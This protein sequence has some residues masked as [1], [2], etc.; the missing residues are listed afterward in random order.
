MA[1]LTTPDN[2]HVN[3]RWAPITSL[4]SRLTRAP[5][6]V[7]VKKAT[8]M[9]CTWREHGAAQVED[10]ALA[11]PRRLPALR[12]ADGGLEQRDEAMITAMRHPARRR[13]RS[14]ISST[15][16]PASTGV[17]TVSTAPTTLSMRNPPSARRC[18]RANSAM[19]RSVAR[20]NRGLSAHR[21]WRSRAPSSG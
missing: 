5:V 19:R 8:G 11:D 7:R 6:R 14:T 10:Q 1:L 15:T 20:S 17:A 12:D 18:G 2:V 9:R 21:G 16:R 13:R 4:L 3:A